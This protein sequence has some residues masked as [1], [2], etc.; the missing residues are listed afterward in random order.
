M[1]L[2]AERTF[3]AVMMVSKLAIRCTGTVISE[4]QQKKTIVRGERC[5]QIS[6]SCEVPRTE[7]RVGLVKNL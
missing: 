1:S 6:V 5:V 2:F 3:A 7:W 4:K